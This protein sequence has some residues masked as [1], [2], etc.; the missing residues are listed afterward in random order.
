[1]QMMPVQR[2]SNFCLILVTMPL[3]RTPS[4]M[5]VYQSSK[6]LL[7]TFT[8]TDYSKS[9]TGLE[10]RASCKDPRRRILL[11]LVALGLVSTLYITSPVS[12]FDGLSLTLLL[13]A[14]SH[15]A[16]LNH[17]SDNMWR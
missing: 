17:L 13:T 1:M 10:S 11:R 3:E 12:V 8:T 5:E 6:A 14:Q 15:A 7:C 16:R 9:T 4:S 2:K